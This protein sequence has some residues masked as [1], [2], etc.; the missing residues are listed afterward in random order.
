M[1]ALLGA[2]LAGAVLT[3]GIVAPAAAAPTPL[4]VSTS[5]APAHLLPGMVAAYTT[6]TVSNP[7]PGS[8]HGSVTVTDTLPAGL[9]MTAIGGAGWS[10]AG[11]ACSRSDR[12]GPHAAYP[13][14]RVVVDV[15]ASVPAVLTNTVRLTGGG[16]A[17]ESIPAR[18]ACAY[19][20]PVGSGISFDGTDSGVPNPERADGCTLLDLIWAS[21]PFHSKASF[22]A[23]VHRATDSF[24]QN[25]LLNRAQ[26][27]SVEVAAARSPVGT[28]DDRSVDN[29]CANRIALT[30]DDGTSSYRPALLRLLRDK[31][32]HATFF[33]NGVRVQANPQVVAFEADEGHVVLNH[34]FTHVH[35]EQLTPSANVEEVLH[36]ERV[37]AAAGAPLPFKG[38]RPPFGGSDPAVQRTLL[39]LGYTYFLNRINGEDWLPDKPASAIRDDILAQLTPGVIIGMHDGP[40]DTPAGA[41][42]VEAVG[43]IIDRARELGYCFGVVGQSG[44]VVADRYVSSGA[45]IPEI[46]NPVPYHLPLAFGTADR[47]PGPWVRIPSP[48]HLSAA[49]A[50]AHFSRGGT[51]TLTLT[52]RNVG[53]RPGDGSPVTVLPTVPSGLSIVSVG[54]PGWACGADACVRSD[55]LASHRSYPPITLTVRVAADA[56]PVIDYAPSLT[57]HGDTWTHEASDPITVS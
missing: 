15:A 43:M 44:H 55:I 20:W 9:T 39:D 25:G 53:D 50:P 47:I 17:S 24:V 14:I 54:G 12:L 10:C 28:G 1:R 27:R 40:I 56:P 31:Q 46:T 29:T 3:A 35:M 34:T 37:L 19:G 51:G 11:L 48:L 49:H 16:S 33:D 41:A 4:R 8:V 52:V 42:T 38:I 2:A 45:P 13:P 21:E 30:F 26:Q 23:A 22:L 6:I 57:A 36:N 7:G 5:H 32:V 18:D